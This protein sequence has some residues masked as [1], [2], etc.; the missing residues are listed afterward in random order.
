MNVYHINSYL[1]GIVGFNHNALVKTMETTVQQ[2]GID[3]D[4]V[5]VSK[6]VAVLAV[7]DN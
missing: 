7:Q 3:T 4:N 2:Q 1:N 6:P 5:V